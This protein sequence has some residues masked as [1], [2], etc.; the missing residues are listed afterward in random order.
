MLQT[1]KLHL[2]KCC[3]YSWCSEDCLDNVVDFV[4]SAATT[5]ALALDVVPTFV[6]TETVALATADVETVPS[7]IIMTTPAAYL[8]CEALIS[9]TTT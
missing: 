4:T 6:A 1:L 8:S 3:C 5:S 7:T 2:K 9:I